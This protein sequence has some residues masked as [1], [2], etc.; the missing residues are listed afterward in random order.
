[1]PSASS[2]SGMAIPQARATAK[3]SMGMGHNRERTASETPARLGT[4]RTP[5][6][7]GGHG[8]T[9]TVATVSSG[10]R[11]S[12]ASTPSS[13]TVKPKHPIVQHQRH[14]LRRRWHKIGG[15]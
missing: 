3:A 7:R 5:L 14:R 10:S 13:S 9:R 2:S 8:A 1:M 12:I 6:V 4:I 11:I 15:R